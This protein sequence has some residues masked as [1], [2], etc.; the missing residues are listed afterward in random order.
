MRTPIEK[1]D[2]KGWVSSHGV[3]D[4]LASGDGSEGRSL[5]PDDSKGNGAGD[6]ARAVPTHP[7]C[8]HPVANSSDDYAGTVCCLCD[9]NPCPA[10]LTFLAAHEEFM[11]ALDKRFADGAA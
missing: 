1:G 5:L 8:P 9:Q 2:A 10:G 6:A 4:V 3:H 7:F 11:D